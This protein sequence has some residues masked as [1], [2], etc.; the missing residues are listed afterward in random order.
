MGLESDSWA[1]GAS[2]KKGGGV[3]SENEKEF[4]NYYG[5]DMMWKSGSFQLSA[6]C[7]YDQYGFGRP[8]FNPLYI[9]WIRSIYYRDVSSGQQGVPCTGVG[10]YVNLDYAGGPWNA[11]L[12]YGDF[13]PLFTGTAPDQRVEHRA[14][15][16]VAYRFAKPLQVYSILILENGGYLAQAYQPRNGIAAVGGFQYSF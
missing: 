4:S 3:G 14:L 5:V 1:L 13:Y 7:I 16:K 15:A 10:Y 2:A 6:E 12:D 11:T 9:S 8:G